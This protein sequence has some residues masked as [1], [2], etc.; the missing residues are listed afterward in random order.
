M[1][2]VLKNCGLEILQNCYSVDRMDRVIIRVQEFM[3][4]IFII[5][6]NKAIINTLYM[7]SASELLYIL[8]DKSP[9]LLTKDMKKHILCIFNKD[10]FFSC[11]KE[12][13]KFW[14]KII[15]WLI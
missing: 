2:E 12:N 3:E 15:N 10:N 13:L 6:E 1:L 5:I 9:I 11:S 4:D 7:E 8:L 14:G